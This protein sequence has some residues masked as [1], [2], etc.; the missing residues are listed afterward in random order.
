MKFLPC[1]VVLMILVA[2]AC[3]FSIV[4]KVL[5]KINS[6]KE[7]KSNDVKKVAKEIK[8]DNKIH[9]NNSSHGFVPSQIKCKLE[10]RRCRSISIVS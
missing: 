3:S 9:K 6:L 7:V 2:T 10:I 1:F 8:L 4:G 5:S